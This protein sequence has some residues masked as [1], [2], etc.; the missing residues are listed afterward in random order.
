MTGLPVGVGFDGVLHDSAGAGPPTGQPVEGAVDALRQLLARGPVFVH[1]TRDPEQA[2]AWL[3]GH[4][5]DVTPDPLGVIGSWAERGKLLVTPMALPAAAWIDKP[6]VRFVSWEQALAFL[7]RE[8][9]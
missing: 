4:G 9:G 5:F 7:D 1:T 6:A 3:Y 2:A 8:P